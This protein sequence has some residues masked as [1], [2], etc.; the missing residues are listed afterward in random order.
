MAFNQQHRIELDSTQY[1][2]ALK[3]MQA[4]T[5]ASMQRVG[6]SINS[7]TQGWRRMSS[8]ITSSV[9][10][11]TSFLGVAGLVVGVGTAAYMAIE[12][13]ATASARAREEAAKEGLERIRTLE[14]LRESRRELQRMY[15]AADAEDD[16]A[17]SIRQRAME[18]RRGIDDRASML[19]DRA[20]ELE[21]F[22]RD[23]TLMG[24]PGALAPGRRA[25]EDARA[26]LEAVRIEQARIAGFRDELRRDEAAATRRLASRMETE[27]IQAEARRAMERDRAGRDAAGVLLGGGAA[28][29]RANLTAQHEERMRA[30]AAEHAAGRANNSAAM[31]MEAAAH[32]TRLRNIDERIAAER[33]ALRQQHR[34]RLANEMMQAHDLRHRLGLDAARARGDTDTA[35]RMEAERGLIDQAR[36]IMTTPGLSALE[37][38]QLVG[39]A[40]MSAAARLAQEATEQGPLAF[41]RDRVLGAG[42]AAAGGGRDFAARV[43]GVGTDTADRPQQQTAENTKKSADKLGEIATAMQSFLRSVGIY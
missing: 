30:L 4:N 22:I 10:S 5:N 25:V 21:Q 29:E 24:E 15:A 17:R 32:A 26:E 34:A 40:T 3:R 13:L 2:S 12:R 9:S 38:M 11:V 43:L 6:Q 27:R 37:R 14:T 35:R 1:D 42:L 39:Q 7:T 18:S 19:R 23:R 16:G 20:T 28:A 8:A 33:D 31:A 41:P 36:Q